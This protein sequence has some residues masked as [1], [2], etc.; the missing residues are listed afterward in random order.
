M[1]KN[2]NRWQGIGRFGQDPE[3]RYT[4]SGDAVCQFTMACSD[5]YKDKDGNKH[6]RTEWVR[7]VAWRKSAELI[8]EYMKKGSKIYVEGKLATRKWQDQSGADRYQTEVV[9]DNFEFLDSKQDSGQSQHPQQ[10]QQ[11]PRQQTA[12]HKDEDFDDLIPF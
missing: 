11:E 2:L 4:P 3:M 7:C 12:H 9:V 5:D 8:S 1:A 6:E 10:R